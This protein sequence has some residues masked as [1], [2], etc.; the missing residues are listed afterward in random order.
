MTGLASD[1]AMALDPARIAT[2]CG[3][4]PDPWQESLLRSDAPRILMCCARQTGKSTVASLIA[5]STAIGQPSALVLLVSPSQRQ[6]A[7]LFRSLMVHFRRLPAAPEIK[8]ESVL[9]VE[10]ANGSRII[11]L[12]GESN[13][14]RG[15]SGASLIILDEAARINAELLAAVRPMLATR[16]DSR[17][18][19]LST[20]FGKNNWFHDAWHGDESWHRVR[21]PADQCPRISKEFL[22]E[23]LRELGEQRFQ[24]EY[25]LA[26]IEDGDQ[27]IRD[28]FF[29]RAVSK[30]VC[31]LWQ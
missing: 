17:L 24:E 8:S 6:S 18:I 30:D 14:V 28:E 11:A 21:V 20:P 5:I 16:S 25:N 1:L 7:E 26:F 27:V 12:P 23:E 31:R 2:A 13:T 4:K 15:Y 19:V 3:L 10:L 9:R 22:E 29:N